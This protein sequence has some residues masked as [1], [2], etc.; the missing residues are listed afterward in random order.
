MERF[1][2]FRNGTGDSLN[3]FES[4]KYPGWFITTS[5]EDYKPVQMCKQQSSHLQLFTL[6][7]ETVVS[8]NEIWFRKPVSRKYVL[9]TSVNP[10]AHFMFK[11]ISAPEN[12]LFCAFLW[13]HN[14]HNMRTEFCIFYIKKYILWDMWQRC[15]F[16]IITNYV[17]YLTLFNLFITKIVLCCID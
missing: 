2:F 1:L 11:Y 12:F 13:F 17:F 5:K 9:G 7:D 16:T 14:N 3:T 15:V 10:E 8:Q 4:V 6:H